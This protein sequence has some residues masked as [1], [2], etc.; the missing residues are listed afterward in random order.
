M[1]AQGQILARNGGVGCGVGKSQMGGLGIVVLGNPNWNSER[2][3][4]LGSERGICGQQNESEASREG[5]KEGRRWDA[6]RRTA[7]I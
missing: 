7:V 4:V 5:G 3:V 6:K 2:I 1:W